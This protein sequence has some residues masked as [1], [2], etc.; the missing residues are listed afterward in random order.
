MPTGGITKIADLWTPAVWVEGITEAVAT[1]PVLLNAGAV[2][3]APLFDEIATGP[4]KTAT[5]P[6]WNDPTD[7]D[8][9][10]Q[11]ESTAPSVVHKLATGTM[12][13]VMCNRVQKWGA[14]ALGA[15]LSGT[16]PLRKTFDFLAENRMKRRQKTLLAIL[17]GIMGT[18]AQTPDQAAGCLRACRKDVFLEAGASPAAG[19]LFD[20]D[21]FID[22]CALMGELKNRLQMG[23]IFMHSVVEGALQKEDK[24]SFD[25]SVSLLPFGV[26]TYRGIPLFISDALVRAGATSGYVYDTYII[27][28]DA[29]AMGEKP[30]AGDMIDVASLQMRE[31][32]DTNDEYL[33]DR[34]RFLIH[35]AGCSYGGSPA[36]SS[37]TDAELQTAASWTTKFQSANRSGIV[38]IRTNG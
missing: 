17:R 38:A 31:D 14:S 4:A 24:D 25:T 18:G 6:V 3:K 35:P 33:Y 5:I 15:Q 19:Q 13:A 8:E 20:S 29:L 37:P 22:S 1:R 36:G 9:E 16:D 21:L 32:K 12:S 34:T 10:V 26:R 23:A 28:P 11:V 7:D 27:A 30:Q 2:R